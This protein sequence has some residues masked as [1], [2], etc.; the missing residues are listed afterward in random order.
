MA[1]PE[2][3][4]WLLEGVEAWNQRRRENP[5]V[6]DLSSVNISLEF[7]KKRIIKYLDRLDLSG[8]NLRNANL[9]STY[10]INIVLDDADLREAELICSKIWHCKARGVF[11]PDAKLQNADIS[12]TDFSK[13]NL[14]SADLVGAK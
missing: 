12:E 3:V 11:M 10:L 14:V 1:N 4:K 7:A 5:F 2:H 8:I 9:K 6:P 13:A